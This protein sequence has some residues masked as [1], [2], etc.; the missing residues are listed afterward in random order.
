MRGNKKIKEKENQILFKC[1][2]H[3]LY[4]FTQESESLLPLGVEM[5]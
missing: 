3:V 4:L 5:T 1:L 2:R